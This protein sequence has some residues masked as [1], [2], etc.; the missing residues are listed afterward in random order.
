MYLV[1]ISSIYFDTIIVGLY[2]NKK[3]AEKALLR[4][5][6][7]TGR[8]TYLDDIEGMKDNDHPLNYS[9][10][11]DYINGT[12][13]ELNVVAFIEYY[14]DGFM[15]ETWTYDIKEIEINDD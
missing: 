3:N 1:F 4:H 9:L 10:Y 5:L 8:L 7:E 11:N 2:K 14:N 6:R 12:I 15:N 13:N